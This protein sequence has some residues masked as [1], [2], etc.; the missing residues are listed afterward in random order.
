MFEFDDPDSIRE[1]KYEGELFVDRIRFISERYRGYIAKIFVSKEDQGFDNQVSDVIEDLVNFGGDEVAESYFTTSG[2]KNR[3]DL[4]ERLSMPLGLFISENMV[5]FDYL[6][7]GEVSIETAIPA[8]LGLF[9]YLYCELDNYIEMTRQVDLLESTAKR[10][11]ES[12]N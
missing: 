1:V 9:S 12:L 10:I 7:N 4:F 2:R 5:A 11:D 6:F 8:A 3:R